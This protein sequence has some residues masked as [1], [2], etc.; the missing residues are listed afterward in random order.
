MMV[1][2][3]WGAWLITFLPGFLRQSIKDRGGV[4]ASLSGRIGGLQ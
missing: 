4:A 1:L 2:L 3:Y